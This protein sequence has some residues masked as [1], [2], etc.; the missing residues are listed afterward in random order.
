MHQHPAPDVKGAKPQLLPNRQSAEVQKLS[1]TYL[2]V[3]NAGLRSKTQQAQ[4]LLAKAREELI[5]KSLVT[6]QA[7]YLLV[8]LRQK[9]LLAPNAYC[10]RILNLADPAQAKRILEEMMISMLNELKDLPVKVVD[11]NW[12]ESLE[13][14][15]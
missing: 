6:K 3:R 13:N 5:P 14:K 15:E 10:R 12:L 11:P 1:K 8:S 9:M 4:M 7:A 2:E